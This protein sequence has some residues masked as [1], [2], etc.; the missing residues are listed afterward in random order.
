MS[1]ITLHNLL[2]P[3]S[4][5][6][7]KDI[8]GGTVKGVPKGLIARHPFNGNHR[9]FTQGAQ[10]FKAQNNLLCISPGSRKTKAWLGEQEDILSAVISISMELLHMFITVQV[11]LVPTWMESSCI[12]VH[13]RDGE[14]EQWSWW[15]FRI[16]NWYSLPV[17]GRGGAAG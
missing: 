17:K 10:P 4:L 3:F 2:A 12:P 15:R 1:L 7:S 11:N 16:G 14:R 9:T 13:H 6:K 8:W 5:W